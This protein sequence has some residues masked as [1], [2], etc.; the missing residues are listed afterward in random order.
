MQIDMGMLVLIFIINFAYITLN[1]VRFLLVMR[2]I[3]I[4]QLLQVSL[5]LRF[6]C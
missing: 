3:G 5:R 4:L 2:V 6:M 1:T